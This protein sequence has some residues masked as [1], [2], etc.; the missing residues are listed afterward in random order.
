MDLQLE[1][2]SVPLCVSF[3]CIHVCNFLCAFLSLGTYDLM[4]N[5]S[6]FWSCSIFL[7]GSCELISAPWKS[8]LKFLVIA[9]TSF[10]IYD[11]LKYQTVTAEEI[12][13]K[14]VNIPI[15]FVFYCRYVLYFIWFCAALLIIWRFWCSEVHICSVF[16]L[17]LGYLV[18][19]AFSCLNGMQWIS[20]YY[21]YNGMIITN[22]NTIR[23][24]VA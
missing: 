16:Q 8:Q 5:A 15:S 11:S 2:H 24:R 12:I 23:V 14:N 10:S 6:R 1:V 18:S 9:Y 3:L 20:L 22:T 17:L 21:Q 7:S 4:I 13:L 19:S